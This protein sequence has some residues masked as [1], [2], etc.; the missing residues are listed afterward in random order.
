MVFN[1]PTRDLIPAHRRSFA[2]EWQKAAGILEKRA[3]RAKELRAL[4]H[5][6]TTHPLPALRIGDNVVI[7]HHLTKRWTTPGVIVEVGAFRDYLVKTPAGRLFRRNRRFLRL[8]S[9]T[10]LP[11]SPSPA[12]NSVISHLLWLIIR[13]FIFFLLLFLS[14]S[15]TG[16]NLGSC[17]FHKFPK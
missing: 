6:R 2:P 7:Q 3:L 17:R 10:A 13:P 4:H 11:H 16:Q 9:P 15:I 14:L 5:N 1:R 8:H 12:P